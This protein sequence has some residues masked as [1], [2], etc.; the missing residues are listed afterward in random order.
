MDFSEIQDELRTIANEVSELSKQI[1]TH[2]TDNQQLQ[3]LV[4]K[5]RAAQQKLDVLVQAQKESV[6]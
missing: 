6:W 5:L 3:L 1:R 4:I 2:S